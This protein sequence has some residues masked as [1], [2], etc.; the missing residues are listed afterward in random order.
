MRRYLEQHP[1]QEADEHFG[2]PAAVL[3]PLYWDQNQWHTLLTRRTNHVEEHRGQVS[4]PGG[5]IESDDLNHVQA[6][7]REAHEEIGILPQDVDVLG[8]LRPTRTITHFL[9]TPVVGVIPWPYD[10]HRNPSEVASV[11]GVPLKWLSDPTNLEL[12]EF[13]PSPSG[14]SFEIHYFKAYQG[15]VIWGATGRIVVGFL[16]VLREL[17]E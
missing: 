13:K 11:F 14:P 9:I 2:R 17:M 3:I 15:E 8:K 12:R 4:F 1:N 7:L 5:M 16:E 10:L 6:A